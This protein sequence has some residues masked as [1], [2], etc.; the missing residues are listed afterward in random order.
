MKTSVAPIN[1]ESS[2]AFKTSNFTIKATPKAFSI[3]SDG[4]YSD[5]KL[6]IVR[7]LGCNAYDSHVAAGCPEKPFEVHL[8]TTYEPW[9]SIRD[10]GTGLSVKSVMKLYTTYFESTKTESNAFV[11]ALGLGSKSPFSYTEA[12]QVTTWFEGQKTCFNAFLSE[13]RMPAISK[14]LGPIDCDEP[15]G[16]EV[17]FGV[18]GNDMYDFNNRAAKVFKWFSVRPIGS[19]ISYNET[20]WTHEGDGFKYNGHSHDKMQAIQGNIAYPIDAEKLGIDTGNLK[21]LSTIGLTMWFDIGDL[22]FAASREHLRYDAK[23]KDNILK[24]IYSIRDTLCLDIE[25]AFNSEKNAWKRYDMFL[26]MQ[27]GHGDLGKYN[28]FWPLFMDY[29]TNSHNLNDEKSVNLYR[30]QFKK[31]AHDVSIKLDGLYENIDFKGSHFTRTP[32]KTVAIMA[33]KVDPKD[34]TELPVQIGLSLTFTV[35][36]RDDRINLFINDV[37]RGGVTRINQSHPNGADRR[38]FIMTMR[39][40]TTDHTVFLAE[41]KAFLKS[42]GDP[43]VEMA[44][45]LVAAPKARRQADVFYRYLEQDESWR[46]AR[47]AHI[48]APLLTPST[49]PYKEYPGV[50]L[51]VLRC[52]YNVGNRSGDTIIGMQDFRKLITRAR[53]CGIINNTHNIFKISQRNTQKTIDLIEGQDFFQYF[54]DEIFKAASTE[55]AKAYL[56]RDSVTRDLMAQNLSSN[57]VTSF[58]EELCSIYKD[59]MLPASHPVYKGLHDIR[60]E[61]M[62]DFGPLKYL[63]ELL[64]FS[65]VGEVWDVSKNLMEVFKTYPLLHSYVAYPGKIVDVVAYIQAM[66]LYNKTQ[67]I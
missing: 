31:A 37:G 35:R 48:P 4:L 66:D 41:A 52:D 25:K 56:A 8:P 54:K 15:T 51:Y 65:L 10:F 21:V 58:G 14:L 23:T 13:D 64:N 3:L 20:N 60:C 53:K 19:Q 55:S 28:R 57:L 49:I 59:K 67:Y 24:R 40:K 29:I 32:M 5:P 63:T 1:V 22:E 27:H 6:A 62:E 44:S 16:L 46:I 17:R 34:L 7:E 38:S 42:L 50:N 12:F 47:P 26:R 45:T 30:D 18:K 33:P 11:G 39:D 2:K 43:D 61:N 9:L 36:F